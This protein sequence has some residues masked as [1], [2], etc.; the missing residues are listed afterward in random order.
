MIGDYIK[1][2]LTFYYFNEFVTFV[3]LLRQKGLIRS[4]TSRLLNSGCHWFY[5]SFGSILARSFK[6][7]ESLLV[8]SVYVKL[9]KIQ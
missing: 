3:T 8:R 2:L 5:F 6:F 9:M 7:S 1:I 4:I